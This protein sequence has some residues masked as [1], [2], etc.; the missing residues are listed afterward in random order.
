MNR[1]RFLAA[2]AVTAVTLAVPGIAWS[3]ERPC[4]HGAGHEGDRRAG[5]VTHPDPR[6]GIT[7]DA[8]LPDDDVS[9]SSKEAYAA[10]RE[11]PAVL[12]GLYCHCD[13][14]ERDG[15]RSLLSCFESKMPQSCRVCRG[16][17]EL[18]ARLARDGK[19]LA[20]IRKAVDERYG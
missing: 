14:A 1:R 20:E 10:A 8:V 2:T 3:R 16:E 11:F 17:A 15:L 6:P 9:A 5:A 12:D 4:R 18:A 7:A 13:C 19:S